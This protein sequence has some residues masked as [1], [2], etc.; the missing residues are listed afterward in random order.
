MSI[1]AASRDRS[2]DD[3]RVELT[4]L[5][6]NFESDAATSRQQIRDL[7]DNDHELFY[8]AAVSILRKAGE[9]RGVQHLIAILA[10]NGML[11]RAICNPDFSRDEALALGR[12]ARRVD[13]MVD[14]ALA[15]H[16]ADSALDSSQ[17]EVADS[18][19]L[20]DILCEMA[21]AG[22]IMPS[23]MRLMRHPD[24]N[25][26]SKAVKMIGRGSHSI[27]WVM[28][29]LSENDARVRANAV[30]SVWGVDTPEAR[31]LLHFAA[32]DASNRVA[33]NALLGLYYLGDSG[34]LPEIVKLASHE[35]PLFR[36]TAAWVMGETADP[37]FT[38]ALRRLIS[39]SDPTVR[40]RAFASLAQLKAAN[41][42]A[43]VG[44]VWNVAARALSGESAKG[45]RRLKLAVAGNDVRETPKI[46]PLQFLLSEGSQ[47]VTAYKITEKP[48]PEA[49]SVVFVI[50]RSR[51]AAGGAFFEGVLRCLRWKR[52]SDL[53]CVLPY[54]Q[55]GDGEAPAPRDP[56]PPIFTASGD[57]LAASLRETPKKLDSTDLWTGVWR[58]IKQDAGPSRGRRHIIILSST[59]ESRIAGHG[60]VTQLE[61]GRISMQVISSGPNHQLEDFCQRTSLRCQTCTDEDVVPLIERAYLNLLARY[62]IAW[63]P[64]GVGAVPVKVRVQTPAGWGETTVAV[65]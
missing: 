54:I 20:M 40:K 57:A 36:A 62:E 28:G 21:D 41:G 65:E 60:L 64:T 18:G 51:E 38:E 26:R 56:E 14:V 7:F 6:A 5:T 11:V 52:S 19:R 59:E 63:T 48:L 10:A 53:W 39:E 22:R 4:A 42:V 2:A 35:S 13:P 47:Y 55:S 30:E 43:P 31:A 29:R 44:E 8:T 45:L 33:G 15:R 3:I 24:P 9:S 61:G 17:V 49:M 32:S 25:L 34:M 16:L 27:K 23:L 50:P 58:A 37:R 46:A 1:Y 12:T